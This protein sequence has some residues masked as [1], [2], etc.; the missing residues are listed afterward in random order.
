MELKDTVKHIAE[1]AKL[2]FK[3]GEIDLF[4]EQFKEIVE[5][6]DTLNEVELIDVEPLA[7]ITDFENVLRQDVVQPSISLEDALKNAPKKNENFF[8]VPKVIEQ[9]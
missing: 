6:I 5:Y 2:E 4:S 1:L 9:E 8:K 3:E 7:Q